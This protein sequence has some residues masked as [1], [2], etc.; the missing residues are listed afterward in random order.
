MGREGPKDGA[1]ARGWDWTTCKEGSGLTT[2][3]GYTKWV[4]RGRQGSARDSVATGAGSELRAPPPECEEGGDE[5]GLSAWCWRLRGAL[6]RMRSW[7]RHSA[8]ATALASRDGSGQG[9]CALRPDPGDTQCP[10][11]GTGRTTRALSGPAAG[12]MMGPPS[13]RAPC[14]SSLTGTSRPLMMLTRSGEGCQH[15]PGTPQPEGHRTTANLGA[16]HCA[17][18]LKPGEG[19]PL[20]RDGSGDRDETMAVIP[21]A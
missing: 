15:I 17:G 20:G 3:R 13:H 21:V 7:G 4:G 16:G 11:E 1:R 9:S 12:E 10:G 14:S 19:Q 8:C 2:P 18:A 5:P 6:R